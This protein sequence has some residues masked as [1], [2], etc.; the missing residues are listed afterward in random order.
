MVLQSFNFI[1]PKYQFK[2]LKEFDYTFLPFNLLVDQG[3]VCFI[4]LKNVSYDFCYT[5]L[6][7]LIAINESNL[8]LSY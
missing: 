4:R 5:I 8:N 2:V 3:F 6:L 7:L 1:L